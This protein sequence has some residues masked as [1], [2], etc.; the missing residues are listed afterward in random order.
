MNQVSRLSFRS[1]SAASEPGI[2]SNAQIVALDSGFALT[3]APE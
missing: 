2:Q 1:A 3:R